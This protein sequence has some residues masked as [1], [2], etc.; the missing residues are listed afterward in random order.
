MTDKVISRELFH[1]NIDEALLVNAFR[2]LYWT[3]ERHA[4]LDFLRV[5]QK[6]DVEIKALDEKYKGI[7]K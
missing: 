1:L 3:Q 6:D 4:V 2:D 5:L 7:D